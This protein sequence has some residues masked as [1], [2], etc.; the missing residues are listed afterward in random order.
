MN[1][2][3]RNSFVARF[4]ASIFAMLS[5]AYSQSIFGKFVAAFKRS[6]DNSKTRERIVAFFTASPKT[7]F[8]KFYGLFRRF[9]SSV[10][11]FG[12]RLR[13]ASESSIFMKICRSF[14]ASKLVEQ[15]VVLSSVKKFGMKKILI[16]AFA[17]Y[18]PLDWLI[19]DIFKLEAVASIW[20][21]AFL[22]FCFAY[23]IFRIA[24]SKKEVKPRITPVDAPVLLFLAVGIFLVG[25]VSPKFGVAIAGYR[26]VC[27]FMLWFFVLTRLIEDESDFKVLYFAICAMA[28]A[29]AVHGIYQYITKAPIPETW[30]AK[31]EVGVRTRVYSIIGSPN[32]MGALLVMTA[33]MVAACAYY[34]KSMKK[35]VLM[36]ILTGL[37]CIATLF[38]FSRGAWFGLTVAVVVFS[39]LV[40]RRLI[41]AAILGIIAIIIC[42]PEISNRIAFLFT[43][44]FQVANNSGGRG[45]RWEKGL[46]LWSD[47]K[48]FGFGLG[49]FGGAIAMQNQDVET[50]YYFY[51]DN[52]YLKTLVE[53]GLVGL[54]SYI[55]LLLQNMLWT[56]RWLFTTKKDRFSYLACGIFAG[57]IGVLAHSY[58]ENIFEVP[59]MNAYFWGLSAAIMFLGF[60]RPKK[61]KTKNDEE[62]NTEEA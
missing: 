51:M 25:V 28:V 45:Q 56:L 32:I 8:S 11:N 41:V 33:P 19:R 42:V 59:Y 12:K 47:H 53:M 13:P 40:D 4:F 61:N 57:L 1:N 49:R 36:W 26:A 35:K 7:V 43:D 58:F 52:Y 5:L 18:L 22:V 3:I 14:S 30:V 27:Q 23:I 44:D 39:L 20:D 50:L 62:N 24:S 10:T 38:T 17:L 29:I 48:T 6:L 16:G 34:A 31:T 37:L 55:W 54:I 60:I 46:E 21:E 9:N 15:S 2:I